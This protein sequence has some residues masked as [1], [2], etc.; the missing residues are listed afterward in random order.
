MPVENYLCEENLERSGEVHSSG[1]VFHEHRDLRCKL[2]KGK[3]RLGTLAIRRGLLRLD[4]HL[5]SHF[6]RYKKNLDICGSSLVWIKFSS[7]QITS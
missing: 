4:F 7:Y 5:V 2:K 1:E 6:F 3:A